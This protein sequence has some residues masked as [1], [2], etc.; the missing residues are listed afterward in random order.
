M[1]WKDPPLLVHRLRRWTNINP[2]MVWRLVFGYLHASH[3]DHRLTELDRICVLVTSLIQLQIH[4]TIKCFSPKQNRQ[5]IYMSRRTLPIIDVV[6]V[7]TLKAPT[8][9]KNSPR[10]LKTII[11]NNRC[12]VPLPLLRFRWFPSHRK[13]SSRMNMLNLSH[14]PS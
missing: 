11:L 12:G 2:T 6:N 3:G 13:L 7:I 1:Y 10:L 9:C 8:H 14:G 4:R 5:I